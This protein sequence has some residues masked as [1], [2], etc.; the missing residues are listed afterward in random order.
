MLVACGVP[1]RG[2]PCWPAVIG[3]C[4][5]VRHDRRRVTAAAVSD[6]PAGAR[7]APADGPHVLCKEHRA[8]RASPRG[9]RAAPHQPETTPGLGRPSR[10][11]RPDPAATGEAAQPSP[12]HSGH[13]PGLASPTRAQ[14]WT[15]PTRPRAAT[16]R[17]QRR[18]VGEADGAGEPELGLPQ[19]PGRAAQ[20]RPPGRRL[21]DP[22]D[23]PT[24][25]DPTGT[26]PAHR[27]P[28]G[29]SSCVPRPP[30]CS[31]STSSTST[32]R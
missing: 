24:A 19:D 15:Y 21:D 22:P 32:A 30:A 26:G 18:S 20:T 8:H 27:Q 1:E 23:P 2:I 29:G 14:A 13:H 16:D 28:A 10:V 17:C 4:P 11:R 25:P 7:T 6:L 9:R 31:R 5:T 12:G 3:V